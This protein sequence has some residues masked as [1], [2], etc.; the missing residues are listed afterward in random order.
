M[1]WLKLSVGTIDFFG[2]KRDR[3]LEGRRVI[4]ALMAEANKPD[5]HP[6]GRRWI[7][8]LCHSVEPAALGCHLRF[9]SFLHFEP[10]PW[11]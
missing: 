3:R 5:Y 8:D 6:G 1:A 9:A 2:E 4:E 7:I 11:P 10:A